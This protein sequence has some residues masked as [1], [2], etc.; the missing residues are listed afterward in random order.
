VTDNDRKPCE[1][2]KQEQKLISELTWGTASDISRNEVGLL[3]E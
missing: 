1:V 2:V 3:E